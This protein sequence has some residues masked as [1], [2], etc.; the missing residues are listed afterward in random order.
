M[1]YTE[2]ELDDNRKF[3]YD[4]HSNTILNETGDVLN[5]SPSRELE[6][7]EEEAKNHGVITKDRDP[8]AIRILLGHACNYN[9]TYCLQKDIG[10]PNERPQSLFIESFIS[11]LSRNLSFDRLERI[12]LWGGE[13]FLYWKDMVALIEYFDDPKRVFFI[14]TN[15]SAFV[16]KHYEFFKNVKAQVLFNLSH[17]AYG[18]ESLR[19]VDIFKNP[20]KVA[21][22]KKIMSLKNVSLGFGC[23]V[24]SENY[25]LFKINEYFKKFVDENE[26]PNASVTF[27]PARN[28]D[29][30]GTDEYS[31][32]YIVR[33]EQLQD[34]DRIMR[35]FIDASLRDPEHKTI[36][37]NSLVYAPD[38]VIKYAKF[39]RSQSPI[40]STSTCGADSSKVL[41]VDIQGN[42]RLCP[43][44]DT[45]FN[46]G[47]LDDLKSVRVTGLDLKR[48]HEHC[49]GCN[50]KR[51]CKSSCPI[52]YPDHVF[53]SNCAL[54]KVW[55]GNV[56]LGSLRLIFGQ[57]V[58][59]NR[60][61]MKSIPAANP[62]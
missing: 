48:R 30:H 51:L 54:E 41:S 21:I 16:E 3:Y 6:W 18:Q 57:G 50:V 52:K 20:K 24:S 34:L 22:I 59:I 5:L 17:D 38:G 8:F 56:Q 25:D 49:H 7:Y 47:K 11:S 55:R 15:G 23:V 19:G 9:C 58:K 53:S 36:L 10:N 35:E 62:S 45:S 61:G 1:S 60:V 31:A 40:T 44:V 28:Y 37:R 26:I 14:S 29:H 42:V 12:E 2:F 27:I 32:K 39:L 13:P 46:A 43:H 4:S 33:G